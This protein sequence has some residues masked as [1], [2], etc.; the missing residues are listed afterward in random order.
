[1]MYPDPISVT[2]ITSIGAGPIGGGW[3]A[4]FLARGYD[5]TAYLHDTSE[6]E[7]FHSILNTAWGSL[8]D[9]GLA[10]GASLDRLRIV[11]DLEQALEGAQFV[12]ESAPERLEIKQSLYAQMGEVLPPDVVIGSSTSGLTMSEI[13]AKCATPERC[14]I[15]HPF[16]P[17]YLL[18]LVEIVGG[19]KTAPDAVVWAG[20]FYE[21]AG[22]APLLM[23]KEIPGFVATRLQE[24]LWREALHMVAN[25]EATPEDIDI[26]LMN[27]PA[28]RMVSQGQ[29]MAFHVACGAGGM[30]TNLDQFGPALK[31]PWTRLE[32]PELTRELR[33]R[34]VDGCN[35]IAGDRH[36]EDMAAQRD[37][38]IVAV[39]RALR[40]A[41]LD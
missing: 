10:E 8:T 27:G 28:P 11:T 36:F 29:C 30:A 35:D 34:M 41:R 22:K 17:P 16:N 32:A 6:T 15:G 4:H 20:K 12:Q 40:E 14:V 33:G 2:R 5:V 31:L 13:Q 19:D 18:P 1:M 21:I 23:K 26:A 7:A 37:R 25:G 38:E 9:L 24:A 3:A 39:L